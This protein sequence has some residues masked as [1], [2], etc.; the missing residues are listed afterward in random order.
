MADDSNWCVV[1]RFSCS[2]V[3]PTAHHIIADHHHAIHF[4]THTHNFHLLTKMDV[5]FEENDDW[6][7]GK[8]SPYEQECLDYF[9][10]LP[11]VQTEGESEKFNYE[12][13]I[14]NYF[15]NS[16]LSIAQ[17]H[18]AKGKH[19]GMMIDWFHKYNGVHCLQ[20]IIISHPIHGICFNKPRQM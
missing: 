15:Q 11:D 17:L 8:Y 19:N 7:T 10:S 13:K 18:S 4:S 20:T 3:L 5:S 1:G 2:L 12:R 6:S 9:E 14:W 16:A